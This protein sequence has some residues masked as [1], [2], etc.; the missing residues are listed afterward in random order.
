MEVTQQMTGDGQEMAQT[1]C[2]TLGKLL[3][4]SVPQFSFL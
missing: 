2:V 3:N 4:L 1:N